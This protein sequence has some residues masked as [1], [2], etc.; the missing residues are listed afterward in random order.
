MSKWMLA[1]VGAM[2]DAYDVA[3]RADEIRKQRVEDEGLAFLAG[4]VELRRTTVRPVF[5][6]AGALLQKHGHAFAIEEEEFVFEGGGGFREAAIRLRITPAGMEKAA[7]SDVHFRE[8][9][10]TTRH[11]NKTISITNGAVPQSGSMAGLSGGF[12]L[13]QINAQLVE[14]EIVKLVA[15]LVRP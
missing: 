4:F 3:R 10:L 9:S 7:A 5:E 15:A 12:A 2:L 14:Q 6:A 11:Y 8:L 1:E 13:S